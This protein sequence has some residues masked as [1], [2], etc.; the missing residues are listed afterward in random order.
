M[1][2][3]TRINSRCHSVEQALKV[4]QKQYKT[5][6]AELNEPTGYSNCWENNDNYEKK[7]LKQTLDQKNKIKNLIELD[8]KRIEFLAH[9]LAYRH[10]YI[11]GEKLPQ[12]KIIE[13]DDD[14]TISINDQQY[15]NLI[16]LKKSLQKSVKNVIKKPKDCMDFGKLPQKLIVKITLDKYIKKH[17]TKLYPKVPDVHFKWLPYVPVYF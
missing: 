6:K 9:I 8:K 2:I 1:D 14:Y 12:I 16:Q 13:Q 10:A 11:F 3:A 7:V 4:H 5:I 15:G 17:H